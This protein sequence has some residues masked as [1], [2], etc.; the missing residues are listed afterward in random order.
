V[1]ASERIN[2]DHTACYRDNVHEN[3]KAGRQWCRPR[4]T[5]GRAASASMPSDKPTVDAAP[6]T[7]VPQHDAEARE[8]RASA[9][10]RYR[11]A[12]VKL[13]LIAEAP[14]SALDRYLYFPDVHTHDSLFRYVAAPS[15]TLSRHG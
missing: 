5:S 11:P 6:E 2:F 8:R 14:P 12:A 10:R 3:R 9:A 1:A 15:S 7:P 13:V 4:R